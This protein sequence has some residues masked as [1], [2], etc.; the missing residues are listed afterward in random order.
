MDLRKTQRSRFNCKMI[1]FNLMMTI[2]F[3]VIFLFGLYCTL[4]D[5]VPVV[6]SLSGS[7]MAGF[8]RFGT[9][10][11]ASYVLVFLTFLIFFIRVHNIDDLVTQAGSYELR[12]VGMTLIGIW[13]LNVVMRFV[14]PNMPFPPVSVFILGV[15]FILLFMLDKIL[16]SKVDMYLNS[17]GGNTRLGDLGPLQFLEL[18]AQI[19]KQQ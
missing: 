17:N 8:I 5:T 9:Y 14:I 12:W 1:A 7:F 3:A 10:R 6:G 16:S 2:L 11:G 15:I 18:M 19:F 4:T 13:A